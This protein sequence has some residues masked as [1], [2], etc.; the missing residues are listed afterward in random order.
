MKK[1]LS[2]SFFSLII[3]TS[4]ASSSFQ[5]CPIGSF[6]FQTLWTESF[7]S[8]LGT[9]HGFTI[10]FLNDEKVEK[11][12]YLE[13]SSSSFQTAYI[14]KNQSTSVHHFFSYGQFSRDAQTMDIYDR[15]DTL[16]GSVNGQWTISAEAP[17][18]S[19]AQF[20][21]VNSDG[22]VLG[23]CYVTDQARKACI[24]NSKKEAIAT[25]EKNLNFDS[26]QVKYHWDV[27][28]NDNCTIP[29]DIMLHLSSYIAEMYAAAYY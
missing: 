25:M 5:V 11:T 3:S 18:G 17:V 19:K 8:S 1:L 27:T 21:I 10:K 28:L 4:F 23:N 9:F 20:E 13:K 6:Y 24:L 14:A 22:D 26:Y 2:I 12:T 29:Q 16:I 7:V 15:D